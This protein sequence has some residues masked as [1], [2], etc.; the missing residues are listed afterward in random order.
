MKVIEVKTSIFLDPNGSHDKIAELKQARDD[1]KAKFPN[2]SPGH[3]THA[4]EAWQETANG[5]RLSINHSIR[6]LPLF[7]RDVPIHTIELEDSVEDPDGINRLM[8]GI[9]ETDDGIRAVVDSYLQHAA[10]KFFVIY[11]IL[12]EGDNLAKIN[13]LYTKIRQSQAHPTHIW[14]VVAPTL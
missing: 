2:G 10:G 8:P 9:Y 14:D 1:H 5:Y 6:H 11:T 13:D 7:V 12:I 3:F 4:G